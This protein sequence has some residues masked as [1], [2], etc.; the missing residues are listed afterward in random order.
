MERA[1]FKEDAHGREAQCPHSDDCWNQDAEHAREALPDF[2]VEAR[3]IAFFHEACHVGVARD[4]DRESKDCDERVHDAVSVVKARNAACAKVC[5]KASD[6][7]FKAE[8]GT[9]AKGHREH[10]LE[11]AD[12]VRVFWFYD[13]FIM[14]AAALG[15]KDLEGEKSDERTDWN[16]PCKSGE[17][18]IIAG[19]I[20][21]GKACGTTADN[22]D[23]VDEA[24]E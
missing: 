10:H 18:V 4:A 11:I 9:Y 3:K 17:T 21:E 16:A 20:R 23:I 6:D 8:H 5:A 1:T 12:D 13:K 24:C 2:A 7:K 15:S 19:V 14:D 22:R